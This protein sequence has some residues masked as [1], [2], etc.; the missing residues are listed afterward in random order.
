MWLGGTGE[1]WSLSSVT[2]I[3]TEIREYSTYRDHVRELAMLAVLLQSSEDL[4][5][6]EKL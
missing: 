5:F 3:F 4:M 6:I 1:G 2:A